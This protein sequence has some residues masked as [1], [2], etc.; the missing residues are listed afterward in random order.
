MN[1]RKNIIVK[2]EKRQTCT[3]VHIY[4]EVYVQNNQPKYTARYVVDSL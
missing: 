3:I 1:S 2:Q 4:V